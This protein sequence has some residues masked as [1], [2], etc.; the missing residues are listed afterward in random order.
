MNYYV[1]YLPSKDLVLAEKDFVDV[2][3]GSPTRKSKTILR[4]RSRFYSLN[5][6]PPSNDSQKCKE[7]KNEIIEEE[8]IIVNEI[9]AGTYHV[10][11][12]IIFKYRNMK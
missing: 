12:I 5:K 7:N 9:V 10:N 1:K 2:P 4:D 3:V 8:E 6:Y 11:K